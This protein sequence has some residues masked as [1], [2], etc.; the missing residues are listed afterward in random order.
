[1]KRIAFI[2]SI[3]WLATFVLST[4]PFAAGGAPATHACTMSAC[5]HDCC[6]EGCTC[7][8]GGQGTCANDSGK[9]C[10]DGRCDMKQKGKTCDKQCKKGCKKTETEKK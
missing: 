7:C 5:T 2:L 3:I 9:C 4:A 10:K 1:M 8:D 6:G